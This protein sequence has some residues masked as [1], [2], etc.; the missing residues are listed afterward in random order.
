MNLSA[1]KIALIAGGFA[2]IGALL[3]AWLGYRFSLSLANVNKRRRA[4]MKLREAF[5]NELLA[6]KPAKHAMQ[7]D[8]ATLS[9]GLPFWILLT[10]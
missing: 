5:K 4:A 8:L 7:I 2:I 10:S 3:A 1:Y 6:L 9:T